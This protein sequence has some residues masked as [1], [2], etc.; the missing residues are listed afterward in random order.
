MHLSM[1][2]LRGGRPCRC[3]GFDFSEE[4]AQ[5]IGQTRSNPLQIISFL[6]TSGQMFMNENDS[7]PLKMISSSPCGLFFKIQDGHNAIS[8]PDPARLLTT[9]TRP[10]VTFE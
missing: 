3:W 6:S 7:L 9:G 2:N 5:N 1:L 10:R 8:F 4:F